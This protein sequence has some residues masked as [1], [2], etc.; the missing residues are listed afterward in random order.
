MPSQDIRNP[1]MKIKDIPKI[2]R[3]CSS[4]AL[5]KYYFQQRINALTDSFLKVKLNI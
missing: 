5:H 1:S 2:F 4:K 3:K